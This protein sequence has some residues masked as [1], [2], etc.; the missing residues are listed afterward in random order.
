MS[1]RTNIYSVANT[2][3]HYVFGNGRKNHFGYSIIKHGILSHSQLNGF[4]MF[5]VSG[6][7]HIGPRY[8]FN[9]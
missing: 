3:S 9:R 8:S 4:Y 5:R 1:T 6:Y 2:F 7:K